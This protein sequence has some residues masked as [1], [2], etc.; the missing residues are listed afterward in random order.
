MASEQNFVFSAN[1]AASIQVQFNVD[2]DP[3]DLGSSDVRFSLYNYFADLQVDDA[4]NGLASLQISQTVLQDIQPGLYDSYI[5]VAGNVPTLVPTYVNSDQ[6]IFDGA[7]YTNSIIVDLASGDVCVANAG[8]AG[9]VPGPRGE[10]G[11][12]G[13]TGP[14]GATGPAG[15]TGPQGNPGPTGADSQVPGPAGNTGPAGPEGPQGTQG[16]PGPEGPDGPRGPEGDPGP[17]GGQGIQGVQGVDGTD[18][19]QGIQGPPGPQGPAGD[20]GEDSIV[21]GPQGPEGPEGPAGPAGPNGSIDILTDVDTT[22]VA[23][24]TGQALV[25]D[26][27]QWEPGNVASGG[28]GDLSAG[29]LPYLNN[30]GVLPI[31]GSVL[32]LLGSFGTTEATG[33]P[34]YVAGLQVGGGWIVP[35]DGLYRISSDVRVRPTGDTGTTV[36][37]ALALEVNGVDAVPD[38]RRRVTNDTA[39]DYDALHIE[40]V[41]NLYQGD[42]VEVLISTIEGTTT[43]SQTWYTDIVNLQGSKGDAGPAG[44]DGVQSS[45]NSVLDIVAVTQAEYDALTPVP[46]TFY[47]IEGV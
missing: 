41:V 38:I 27:G 33:T 3:Y 9:G 16:I 17:Q 19:S 5:T 42:Q 22:T 21:A 35:E 37:I 28:G 13:P 18:G 4:A 12:E 6:S 45:D 20:D 23:P 39:T 26:G 2:G 34:E 30:T 1:D 29:P 25:W 24:I 14:T 36:N 46:T 32:S 47:I 7:V 31:T 11:P 43:Q 44:S 15:A 8:G 10:A 40:G